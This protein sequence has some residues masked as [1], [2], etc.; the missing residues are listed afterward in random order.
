MRMNRRAILYLYLL[1]LIIIIILN[2]II[3]FSIPILLVDVVVVIFAVLMDKDELLVSLAFLL[4]LAS[5]FEASTHIWLIYVI[6]LLA[7]RVKVNASFVLFLSIFVILEMIAHI[8]YGVSDLNRVINYLFT[9]AMFIILITNKDQIVFD[10]M[11]K[12]YCL[13]IPLLIV[14]YILSAVS[15]G[16][17]DVFNALFVDGARFGGTAGEEFSGMSININANTMAYYCISCISMTIVLL[18]R[19]ILKTWQKTFYVILLFF[20]VLFGISTGSRTFII[21][22]VLCVFLCLV[23]SL[24]D[25]KRVLI[26]IIAFLSLCG[27]GVILINSNIPVIDATMA[28]FERSDVSS[29]NGRTDIL[30]EYMEKFQSSESFWALGSGVNGYMIIYDSDMAIHNGIIQVLICCGMFGFLAFLALIIKPLFSAIRRRISFYNYIPLIVCFLF[31][32]TIQLLSPSLLLFP[33]ALAYLPILQD[34]CIIATR[35]DRQNSDF[36]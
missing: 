1:L 4:P 27:I 23:S 5:C 33:F 20:S 6:A 26:S 19:N 25:K 28:R 7:K 21:T 12:M 2:K 29:M 13:A 16:N 34:G 8:Y 24:R 17:T 15:S 18:K 30:T 3:G 22:L 32:Q 10:K 31:L 9:F 14:F 35:D 36:A 11:M